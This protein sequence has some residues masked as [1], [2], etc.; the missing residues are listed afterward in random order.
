MKEA[1]LVGWFC[2]REEDPDCDRAPGRTQGSAH[3]G[4]GGKD[5]QSQW[6]FSLGKLSPGSPGRE[7]QQ[8]VVCT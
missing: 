1:A 4:R 5:E 2:G 3:G 8:A 7:V 6:S